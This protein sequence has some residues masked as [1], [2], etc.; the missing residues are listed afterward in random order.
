M[1]HPLFKIPERKS[2]GNLLDNTKLVNLTRRHPGRSLRR[3]GISCEKHI[4]QKTSQR[5]NSICKPL[6]AL[7]NSKDSVVIAGNKAYVTAIGFLGNI[8]LDSGK[9]DWSIDNLYELKSGSYNYFDTVI[10][11]QNVIEFKSYHFQE[12][13]FKVV[14]V[15]HMGN[16]ISID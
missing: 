4:N 11:S 10:L 9:Y 7:R 1:K 8:N 13:E 16:L 12:K 5:L 3:A 14:T 15:D 2:L 6:E